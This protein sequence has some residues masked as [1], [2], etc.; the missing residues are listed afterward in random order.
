MNSVFFVLGLVQ[1]AL[2]FA[3]AR[4]GRALA[5]RAAREREE[6]RYAPRAGW[7]RV[8]LIIPVAGT[9]PR[10]E[11]ALRSLLAQDY[12][13]FVPVLVTATADD[14]AVA[15]IGRLQQDFP[16]LRHV[17]AGEAA[18]CGQKN[19]N[20]LAGVAAVGDGV[21][22][23]AFC[24]S[25]HHAEPD[26]LRCLV[27]PVAREQAAFATGYHQVEPR[28][29]GLVTL[30]YALCVLLMRLL[31]GVAAFTQPWGGA[32]CMSRAAFLRYDVA[33][34]WAGNV[35]DDCS[36]GAMLQA[37][38][39]RV[40]LCAAALL[41]TTARDHSS[42]VWRAWLERQILFLKFCMPGQWLLLGLFAALMLLPPLWACVDFTRGLLGLGGNAGPFL[43]LTWLGLL[44]WI[45]ADWRRL[46]PSR[47]PLTRWLAAFFMAAAMFAWCYA[48]TVRATG[49]VWHGVR[50]RVGR[51]GTVLG[52][53]REQRRA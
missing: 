50:Y 20:S 24:D 41:R 7:P 17:V 18:H 25:T 31:Q 16:G 2:L 51:G 34:L 8:G 13:D 45:L 49:I 37:R 38:G 14:P 43:A 46:L 35:V 1:C 42:R 52:L 19:R 47:A 44:A 33:R 29:E 22:I 36:L 5:A 15:V 32:M 48:A 3:L 27:G 23:Y 39:A 28:D 11:G 26:F 4:F 9:D 12:P 21:D 53:S 10:M 30:A 6:A 40:R